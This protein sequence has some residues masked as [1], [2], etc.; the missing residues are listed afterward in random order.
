MATA[1]N[2]SALPPDPPRPSGT[3][4]PTTLAALEKADWTNVLLVDE[5]LSLEATSALTIEDSR[6]ER[7]DLGQSRLPGLT[8]SDTE[9]IGCNLANV[10]IRGGSM[11]RCIVRGC[12]LTGL[13]WTEGRFQD[14]H[15]EGCRVDLAT[16][17]ATRFDRVTFDDCVMTQCD[18]QGIGADS[19]RFL[20]C[21][22]ADS[23]VTGARLRRTELRGCDL[24]Q[25]RG[26]ASLRGA[27]LEWTDLVGM[28][29]TFAD[30]LGVRV[31]DAG[32]DPQGV[33][34]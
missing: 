1:T 11:R 12:R 28:A 20:A 16:F 21:A 22:M 31:L 33:A 24:S 2:L 9:L 18:L 5:Q 7:V 30:A 17:A 3:I 23:D 25:L 32:D 26:L 13:S 10:R 29:A 14:V 8:I 34:G 4:A 6:L 27:G 19:L 15:F